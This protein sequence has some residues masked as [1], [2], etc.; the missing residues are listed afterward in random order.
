[1]VNKLTGVFTQDDEESFEMFAVYCGL[2]LHQAK[3]C[4]RTR[5]YS[6]D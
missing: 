1:M 3:V 6:I 5:T 2:A 4:R